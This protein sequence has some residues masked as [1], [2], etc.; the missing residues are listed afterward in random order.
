MNQPLH[1]SRPGQHHFRSVFFAKACTS[2]EKFHSFPENAT[3]L[4]DLEDSIPAAEKPCQRSKIRRL[5]EQGVFKNRTVFIRIN[6]PDQIT[7]MHAD[8]MAC[9]HS[10]IDGLMIPMIQNAAELRYIEEIIERREES[11]QLPKGHN[12]I[13]PLI[14]RPAAVLNLDDIA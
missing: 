6:G 14:E 1:I 3:I 12:S 8:L 4:L 9:L 5:I 2:A 11:L 7:E 13:I 10:D